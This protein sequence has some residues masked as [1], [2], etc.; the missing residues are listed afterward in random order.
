[1]S[2][3]Y[4]EYVMD[5]G[6]GNSKLAALAGSTYGVAKIAIIGESNFAGIYND[7]DNGGTGGTTGFDTNY[8]ARVALANKTNGNPKPRHNGS[9]FVYADGHAKYIPLAKIRCPAAAGAQG[10]FPVINPN[11]PSELP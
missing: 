6:R 8:L 5:N 4:S 10:E 7:W 9:Q 2:Y 3:G 1:M 11:A